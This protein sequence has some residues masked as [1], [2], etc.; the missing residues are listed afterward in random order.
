M[1]DTAVHDKFSQ[2]VTGNLT[3]NQFVEWVRTNR[4]LIEQVGQKD[5]TTLSEFDIGHNDK[6]IQY[7]LS[8]QVSYIW[9]KHV[10]NSP[11]VEKTRVILQGMIEG[12]VGIIKG[13]RELTSLFWKGYGFIPIIFVGWDSE[14]DNAINETSEV[15][16]YYKQQVLDEAGKLLTALENAKD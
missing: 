12:T 15:V 1:L 16:G 4:D 10:S 8:L 13:C 9:A 11:E 7:N 5:Y 2:F 3:T 6:M 14:L